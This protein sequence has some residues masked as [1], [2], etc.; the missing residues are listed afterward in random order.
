MSEAIFNLKIENKSPIELSDL[1]DSFTAV[2]DEYKR[3][4]T[5]LPDP[6]EQNEIKLYV[7]EIKSGSV[8]A[9]LIDYAPLILPFAQNIITIV[10]FSKFLKY[11]YEFLTGKTK[12]KPQLEKQDYLN[13]SKIVNPVAKDNGSQ[14]IFNTVINGDIYGD[15]KVPYLE[16]NAAQNS[17]QREIK[18]IKEPVSNYHEKVVMYWYQARN[19]PESTTGDRA[20]IE[21][22]SNRAVK[23]A[24]MRD[25][26]KL[27]IIEDS[28]NLF[29]H[30]YLV[31]VV[32]ETIGGSP[33]VYKITTMHDKFEKPNEN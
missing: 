5:K 22:I 9:I 23:V 25:D 29:K 19:E 27:S 3:F 11:S 32:V 18:Q 33:V 14:I 28:S 13:L 6:R 26:I 21:S 17:I 16:A 24:F 2:A 15:F 30:A 1:T 8:H 31:D 4:S 12:E 7:K 20:I 10:E